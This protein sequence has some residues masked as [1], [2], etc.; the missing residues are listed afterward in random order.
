V[1]FSDFS[2]KM[3]DT[4]ASATTGYSSGES[5]KLAARVGMGMSWKA[6]ARAK[7][8]SAKA[9]ASDLE[10]RALGSRGDGYEGW[11]AVLCMMSAVTWSGTVRVRN[12]GA[13]TCT[14]CQF[15]S[16]RH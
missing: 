13:V 6:P 4:F 12:S 16:I 14:V 10:A 5:C 8:V 3:S 11:A 7:P 15:M 9:A 1:K 2:V